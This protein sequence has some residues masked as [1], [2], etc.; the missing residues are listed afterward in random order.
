MSV[1][2]VPELDKRL[3][4]LERG[5]AMKVVRPALRAGMKAV[6]PFVLAL[7]P[8]LTGNL[9]RSIKLRAL[10]RKKGR[11]GI[12]IVTGTRD[13]LGIPA[14]SPWYYP[15]HVELG[16]EHAPA[17]SFM[18]AGLKSGQGSALAAVTAKL[19]ERLEKLG[20]GRDPGTDTDTEA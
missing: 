20:M 11:V 15:A 18:R 13:Q 16:T 7:V 5:A 8:Q 14:D 4:E 19:W 9:A 3:D 12:E 17:T 2:G 6:L 10:K 1:L